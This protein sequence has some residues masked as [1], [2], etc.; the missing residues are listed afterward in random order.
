MCCNDDSE[1]MAAAMASAVAPVKAWPNKT[2]QRGLAY[3]AT[4]VAYLEAMNQEEKGR[5][6]EITAAQ[7]KNGQMKLTTRKRQPRCFNSY[8][9]LG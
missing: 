8:L 4:S 6:G 5:R 9:A 7:K 2:N 1:Q 3:T